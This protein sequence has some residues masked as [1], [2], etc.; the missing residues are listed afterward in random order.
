M[1]IADVEAALEKVRGFIALLEQG[2]ELYRAGLTFTEQRWAIERRI[3]E[4]LPLVLRIAD[5][6]DPELV[7]ELKEEGHAWRY[8]P[9]LV[10]SR[11]LAGLLGSLDE[12]ERILGPAG[13]KLAA[14][15]LHP[16]IWNA[17]VSLWGDGD[18]REAV[19]ASAGPLPSSTAPERSICTDTALTASRSIRLSIRTFSAW[20][21]AGWSRRWPT[22]AAAARWAR[23]GTTP[24]A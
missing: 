9:A 11:Q 18:M 16:W 21:I 10:A 6:A 14:A 12:M 4:Q 2:L 13:P 1:E 17:A 15:N 20:S 19:Q 8:S 5:R 23:A 7:V 3:Q 22:F 24:A